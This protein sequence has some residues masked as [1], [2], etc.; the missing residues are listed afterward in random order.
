MIKKLEEFL[1]G[2]VFGRALARFALTVVTGGATWLAGK[3]I[4][5]SADQ[6]AAAITALVGA[7]NSAYTKLSAWREKRALVAAVAV[8]AAKP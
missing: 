3:G 2:Q 1:F 5:L 7:V 8:E 4:E 6:Q